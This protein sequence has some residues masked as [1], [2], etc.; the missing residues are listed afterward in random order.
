MRGSSH[1]KLMAYKKAKTSSPPLKRFPTNLNKWLNCQNL[2]KS[3]NL[4][5]LGEGSV[6]KS[7]CRA[8]SKKKKK[9]VKE[10]WGWDAQSPQRCWEVVIPTL[11]WTGKGTLQASQINPI[12]QLCVH[13]GE[14]AT[15]PNKDC[16]FLPVASKYT[17]THTCISMCAQ[18]HVTR[19]HIHAILHIHT[20][21]KNI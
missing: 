4:S 15:V 8:S 7:A 6:I 2:L 9:K 14:L 12:F 13:L 20:H 17:P 16:Q 21:E 1:Y 10:Y 5:E 11:G 19:I 3:K 18:T